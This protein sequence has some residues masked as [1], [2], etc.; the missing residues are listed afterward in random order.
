MAVEE[1]DVD[2]P[3]TI[4]PLVMGESMTGLRYEF[5]HCTLDILDDPPAAGPSVSGL[6]ID[7][8]FEVPVQRQPCQ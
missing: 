5:D 8:S 3:M 4:T 2:C 7:G 6:V 1:L